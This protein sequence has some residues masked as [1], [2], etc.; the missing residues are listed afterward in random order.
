MSFPR[1]LIVDDHQLAREGLRAVLDGAGADVVGMASTGE[2]SVEMTAALEPDIVLM[3]VRLGDGIDGLEA[4]RRI[5]SLGLNTRVIMLT[6][7]EMPAYVREALAAGAAGY[8]LKDTAIGDLREAI[9][10]VMAGRSALPLDLV[11]AA[12]RAPSRPGGQSDPAVLLTPR[13]Q[14]VLVFVAEGRT[15]KEIARELG[16]S[17][18][19]VKAHVERI[20]GKLG[21]A[22]RTQA[23]VLAVTMKSAAS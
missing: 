6:L 18:A 1:I 9:E 2:E 7:H 4:T 3:D 14:D 21:V 23:A 5:Q 13:E 17:P 19:T 10:Q 16:I 20:I 8:V 12:M 22:D 11:G 15:N